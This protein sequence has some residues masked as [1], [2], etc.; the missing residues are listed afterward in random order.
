VVK[1]LGQV[2]PHDWARFLRERL[3]THE[4]A[5]LAGLAGSGW[6]LVYAEEQS[7][8]DKAEEEH[9]KAADFTYSIGLRVSSE[10]D[11]AVKSVRW[12][13]PAF[14]A[15]V[16]PGAKLLAVNGL[17]YKRERLADAITAAKNGGPAI[18]LLLRDGEQFRS[19]RI[20]Y[21]GG[22]RHPRLQRVEGTPDR[23]SAILAAR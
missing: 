9:D 1:T 23:L 6:Q 22:L 18:E 11:H 8:N 2:W 19:V 5:P 17:A 10:D 3:D 12:D 21:R 13:G 14:A 15:G 7:D 4:R 16:A 20:D